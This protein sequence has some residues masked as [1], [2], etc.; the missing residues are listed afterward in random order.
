M[1]NTNIKK[2]V[3]LA[4]LMAIV[5]VLQATA[6]LLPTLPGGAKLSFVLIPIVLGAVLYGPGAGALLGATFG[7][8]AFYF[9]ATGMDAVGFAVFSVSP[10]GC[11]L[12]CVGKSTVAGCVAGLV[13]KLLVKVNG[14]LATLCASIVCPVLNTGI[15]MGS[16]AL[17][18]RNTTFS[19]DGSGNPD[20][21]ITIVSIFGIILLF[22]AIPE[23]VINIIFSP[24]AQRIV[25]VVKK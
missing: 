24:A 21:Y 6:G 1:R 7:L 13:Y 4:L 11:F 23:L 16:V 15:F 18:F 5:V 8:L 19:S 2:M 14:Y 9:S 22:N 17:F 10:I 12:V 25:K 20:T 3:T